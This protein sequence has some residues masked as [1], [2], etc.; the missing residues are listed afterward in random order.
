MTDSRVLR[1][2]RHRRRRFWTGSVS[3]EYTYL[4]GYDTLDACS[5]GDVRGSVSE[6]LFS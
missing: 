4:R 1:R 5:F 2:R 3:P 6:C